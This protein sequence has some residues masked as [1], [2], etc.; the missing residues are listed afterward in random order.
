MDP[1]ILMIEPDLDERAATATM[2]RA[3]RVYEEG[4]R[5]ISRVMRQQLTEGTEQAGRGFDDLEQKARKAYLGMQDAADKVAREQAKLDAAVERGASN[6]EVLARRVE[7]ARL[8]EI[9]AIERAT[10]AYREYEQAASGAGGSILSGLRSVAGQAAGAGQDAAGSFMSGFAGASALTRLGAA[11]GPVGIAL[12]GTAVLGFAAGKSLA[13]NF[14][15]GFESLQQRDLIGTRLGVDEAT[16][17]RFGESAGAAWVNGWGTSVQ[18]NLLTL[19]FAVHADLLDPASG[20]QQAQQLIERMQTL[21]TV[22]GEDP[23]AIA[24]GSRNLV[25]TGLAA[26]PGEAF[27]LLAAAQGKGL[28]L[29]GDLIDTLEEYGTAW[30]G[31]GLTGQDALGLITQMMDAGI[32][33]TDV[34]ADSLKEL[35]ISVTDNSESTRNA[36]AALGFDADEMN[37]RFAEGGP[38]ARESYGEVLTALAAIEDPT[39]RNN[40]GLALFKTKWEDAKTAIQAADLPTAAADLGKV[41]GA[42]DEATAKLSAHANGWDQLGRSIDQTMG[43]LQRWLAD[44]AIGQFFTQTMPSTLA[45]T[46]DKYGPGGSYWADDPAAAANPNAPSGAGPGRWVTT[47]S[48]QTIWVPGGAATPSAPGAFREPV[49]VPTSQLNRPD[50]ATRTTPVPMPTTGAG[51]ASESLPSAPVLPMQYTSVAGMPTQVA[52]A[53]TRLDEARHALAEKQARTTQLEQTTVATADDIQKARNDVIEAERDMQQAEQALQDARV[54][55]YERMTKES[56]RMA[57]G[58]QNHADKLGQ[59][60]AQLDSDFGVSEGLAGIAD[61]ITRFLANLAFAPA[62]GALSAVQA[63]NGFSRGEAGSGLLGMAGASGAFGD[64]FVPIPSWARNQSASPSLLGPAALQPGMAGLPSMPAAGSMGT[65]SQ[66][67][68]AENIANRFGLNMTSGKRSWAG[69]ASGQSW[70][71]SGQAGDFSN[72]S[73]NTPEMRAFAQYMSDNFAPYL[74][75]LIYSD[76]SFSGNIFQGQPHQYSAGTL[77]DHRDH[78]HVAIKDQYQQMLSQMFGTTTD[79]MGD[80]Y[81]AFGVPGGQPWSA[82]W[83]TMAQKEAS[84]NWQANTGNG[85]YGGLQF[86]PSSWEAAGGTQYAPRPD[87]ATPYQQAMAGENLLALQGPGAW[88]NTFTPGSAGPAAPSQSVAGGRQ[89]GQGLPASG[90][91]GFNGGV[92]GA[93][94]S[95]AAGAAGG[96]GSFGAGG[97]AASAAADLG[98]QL[99]GRAAGAAGQ[100]AGAAAGGLLETFALNDSALADPGRSWLGRLAIAGAGMR[101]ALPNTAGELGGKQNDNMAEGGKQPPPPLTPQQAKQA[102]EDERRS[103][104]PNAAIGKNGTTINNNISVTNQRAREDGT[105]RDI[106][107]AMGAQAFARAPR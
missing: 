102:R 1:L 25:A 46:L 97:G 7:R 76:P 27:D 105:G 35:A 29:T 68:L 73:A 81:D 13:D 52:N 61:N 18:D 49:P 74:Q 31:V 100:Y 30:H 38:V 23:R 2:A 67:G 21:A 57:K 94:L 89:F 83:L 9:D 88:P 24:R 5:D 92:I 41:A 6:T 22:T 15:A 66:I 80:N 95:A 60:G 78:V 4:A 51:G 32:R 87:L 55:E 86:L 77:A 85:Y 28:D 26:D 90:G 91:I 37:R 14:V 50:P 54:N 101:P 70:H 99:L 39:E 93:A 34:A 98:I 36:F 10:Q 47:G 40:I 107:A 48:G 79:G 16:M 33:N 19:Q 63:A 8:G 82:D 64:Q 56:E 58:L 104:D 103:G 3:Q 43:G 44:T 75:E 42:T 96:A 11:G 106:Q 69:T 20:E 71:L 53:Q 72:G 84:G 45:N 59:I 12:A 62:Y 17:A 65:H